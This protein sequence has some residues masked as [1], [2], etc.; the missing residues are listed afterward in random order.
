[1]YRWFRV[2]FFSPN[3]PFFFL[4]RLPIGSHWFENVLLELFSL[5]LCLFLFHNTM[6]LYKAIR[7]Y[8]TNY[9][10][11]ASWKYNRNL[12]STGMWFYGFV[13]TIWFLTG[14]PLI[15]YHIFKKNRY[16]LSVLLPTPNAAFS[17]NLT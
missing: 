10:K 2:S 7:I 13:K 8:L 16:T 17:K 1:M 12:R 5:Q 3:F 9:L 6:K 11:H 14:I 4:C 15:L